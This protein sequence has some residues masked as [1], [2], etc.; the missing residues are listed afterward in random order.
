MTY[1]LCYVIIFEKVTNTCAKNRQSLKTWIK[2]NCLSQRRATSGPRARSGL[3]RPSFRPATLLGN[4]IAM[5]PAKPQPKNTGFMSEI[6]RRVN[7]RTN[8]EHCGQCHES[9]CKLLRLLIKYKYW[10]TEI[11]VFILVT[12][13]AWWGGG[14]NVYNRCVPKSCCRQTASNNYKSNP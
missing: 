1:I 10:K 8:S 4:N 11:I 6:T 13:L 14:S 2:N 7:V 5:R 3:R 12:C 9:R